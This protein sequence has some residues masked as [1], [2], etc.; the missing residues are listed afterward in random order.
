MYFT[1]HSVKIY[2]SDLVSMIKPQCLNSSFQPFQI[3]CLEHESIRLYAEVVQT[4]ENRQVCWLRPIALVELAEANCP[5]TH[6][7]NFGRI[8]DLRRDP[9]L[10]LPAMLFRTAI[11]TEVI[12][13]LSEIGDLDSSNAVYSIKSLML[14]QLIERICLAYPEA[15]C[16]D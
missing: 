4:A 8:H 16:D 15:F 7:L 11:D 1:I 12:P 3:V 10:L 13:L 2:L 9:D 14:N 5:S 6:Q